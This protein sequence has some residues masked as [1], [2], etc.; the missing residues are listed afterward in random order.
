MANADASV[1]PRLYAKVSLSASVAE[2]GSPIF[3]P[4]VV[5]SAIDRVA[6]LPSVNMGARFSSI[7][8]T[9]IVTLIMSVSV[10]SDTVIVTE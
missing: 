10:P 8:V 6:L 2:I 1:P 3:T 5:F 4:A 7:S 9:F